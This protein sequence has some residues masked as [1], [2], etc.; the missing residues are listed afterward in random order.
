MLRDSYSVYAEIRVL[1]ARV[2][3]RKIAEIPNYQCTPV[4][5][6][7]KSYFDSIRDRPCRRIRAIAALAQNAGRALR[8]EQI[9][10]ETL[11]EVLAT[12]MISLCQVGAIGHGEVPLRNELHIVD[13]GRAQIQVPFEESWG[14]NLTRRG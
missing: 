8:Q 11:T 10:G 6:K 4:R 9:P 1:P 12:A 13:A 3:A 5:N 7:R 14:G 2:I